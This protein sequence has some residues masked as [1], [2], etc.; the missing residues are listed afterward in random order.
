M[1]KLKSKA[2]TSFCVC[3]I[4]VLSGCATPT[5]NEGSKPSLPARNLDYA[6][7][8]E[9]YSAGKAAYSGFYNSFEFEGTIHNATVDRAITDQQAKFYEWEESKTQAELQKR[10]EERATKTTFFV[11]FFTPDTK[12]DNLS[13]DNSIWRV[14]LDVGGKR[15]AGKATKI[16][17]LLTDLITTYFYHNRWSTAYLIEFSVPTREVEFQSSSLTITGPLGAKTVI[18]QPEDQE[19]S[20]PL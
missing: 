11:S 14:F 19:S 18:F 12:N 7:V 5:R 1:T 4:I 10:A 17:K 2:L 8:I 13:K 6:K 9:Y 3:A 16:R 20:G 15:Y